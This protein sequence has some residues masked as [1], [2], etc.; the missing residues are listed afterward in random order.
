VNYERKKERK[1][2]TE[3]VEAKTRDYPKCQNRSEAENFMIAFLVV[4]GGS[5]RRGF[6]RA[7]RKGASLSFLLGS[8]VCM[9]PEKAMAPTA[10]L[11]DYNSYDSR[12]GFQLLGHFSFPFS[13]VRRH[14]LA[15]VR[16]KRIKRSHRASR[17][18]LSQCHCQLQRLA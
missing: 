4:V 10:G 14:L 2:W 11:I 18:V 1:R 7:R 17:I 12:S 6:S 5:K 8:A 15:S 9:T 3:I 16:P 13:P